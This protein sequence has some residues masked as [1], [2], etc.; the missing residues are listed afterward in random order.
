MGQLENSLYE[1]LEKRKKC[2]INSKIFQNCFLIY[3]KV[4]LNFDLITTKLDQKFRNC[5]SRHKICMSF[6]SQLKGLQYDIS[7]DTLR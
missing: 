7:H 3:C 2:R 5:F 6:K 4:F 1:W